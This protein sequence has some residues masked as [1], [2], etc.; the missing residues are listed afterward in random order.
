MIDIKFRFHPDQGNIRLRIRGHAG[1]APRGESLVCAGVSAL[2]L[3]AAECAEEMWNMGLLTRPP[4]VNLK[5]GD[6][7]IIVTPRED[8]LSE[9][10]MCF[11]TVQAG[12]YR[13]QRHF[14]GHVHLTQVLQV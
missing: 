6:T 1:D 8:T 2:A 11:W 4:R 14:P 12:L 10:L 13:L 5:A 7:V 3:T 9:A